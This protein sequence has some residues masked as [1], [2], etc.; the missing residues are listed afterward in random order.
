MADDDKAAVRESG[1]MDE[2]DIK[3]DVS[4][5]TP[6]RRSRR[7]HT[8]DAPDDETEAGVRTPTP[9]P[10]SSSAA[11]DGVEIGDEGV[12]RCV[13]GST[14]ENLGLM[15]QC[16]TCKSWQ[17]CACMGMHTEEDC[18]D[19]YYCEQCR[20]ENHIELLRS[21]GFLPAGKMIRRGATRSGG[22]PTFSKES[23]Q[24]LRDAR[25]AIRA[26]AME[27]AARIHG[28]VPPQHE[29]RR[30]S[31]TSSRGTPDSRA[32]KRRTMNSRDFG[33]DGWEQI[34]PELLREQQEN[35]TVGTD[36]EADDDDD[37]RKR[38]RP[39]ES[40]E[41][42]DEDAGHA[43]AASDLAKRRRIVEP[44]R[45]NDERTAP[46]TRSQR[47]ERT[48]TPARDDKPKHSN[49]N[50]HRQR[51][52]E[53][54][55]PSAPPARTREAR[56]AVRASGTDTA[57]RSNTPL[58]DAAGKSVAH[59]T[60]PEHLS[61][62]AYLL[63]PLEGEENEQ[64]PSASPKAG[65]PPPFQSVTSID[66]AIKIRFPQKRMTLGEMRKRVRLTGEYVT[67]I[68]VEAVEREK[69]V[70]FLASVTGERLEGKSHDL[71]MS[72]QLVDQL[73]RD[74]AAFQRRFGASGIVA[75]DE[76]SDS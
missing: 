12:T 49:P 74:L 55:A 65:L 21:L 32:P 4:E 47:K 53:T 2:H 24:A 1:A 18:P 60:L 20:P 41:D 17:H 29:P 58:A 7:M 19:V 13:C 11:V 10:G 5:R 44:R 39:G 66:P 48:A 64:A 15:I 68:Q 34:P 28:A 67:R 26:M 27:N 63:P 69:R 35:S 56:R 16:E 45:V 59:N 33:E 38:K 54:D 23:A 8:H 73:S 51:H 30:S 37:S 62:L 42:G 71:P 14:D 9:P 50:T 22:R 75:R 46:E 76:A 61:H 31:S 40:A 43:H 57:S 36:G 52:D 72:M 3:P 25:D 70:A 6:P